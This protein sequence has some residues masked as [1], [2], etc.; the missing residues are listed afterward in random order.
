MML[1]KIEKANHAIHI[2]SFALAFSTYLKYF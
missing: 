2:C 1:C